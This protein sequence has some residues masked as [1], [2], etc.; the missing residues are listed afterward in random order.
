M[1]KLIEI[2][3]DG[4]RCRESRCK[5]VQEGTSFFPSPQVIDLR[6]AHFVLVFLRVDR[7]GS[8]PSGGRNTGNVPQGPRTCP[9]LSEHLQESLPGTPSDLPGC[10]DDRG[11]CGV[12]HVIRE[13]P[14]Q[15][16]L[17]QKGL[18]HPPEVR[19]RC[20]LIRP[21]FCQT[22]IICD[23]LD[24]VQEIR[25]ILSLRPLHV[26]VVALHEVVR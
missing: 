12:I 4:S 19:Q 24:I 14:V 21:F 10:R 16:G 11:S 25:R 22:R 20:L 9:D 18:D 13:H 2:R 15:K 3:R 17:V 23:R 5:F 8:I 26:G 6:T 1:N 7:L